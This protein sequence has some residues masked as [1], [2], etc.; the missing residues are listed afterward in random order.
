[1]TSPK[2]SINQTKQGVEQLDQESWD[3]VTILSTE[4]DF[5][6][7][8]EFKNI[9]NKWLKQ[10]NLHH[11]VTL[12]PEMVLL[13]ETDQHFAKAIQNAELKTPDG[14]GIIWA[15]WYKRSN[16]WSAIPSLLAFPFITVERITGIDAITTLALAAAKGNQSVYLLGSTSAARQQA[17]SKLLAQNSNLSIHYAPASSDDV[18]AD[19]A[20]IADIKLRR[21]AILL[22]AYGA[23]KQSIWIEQHRQHLA[24]AG[25]RIAIGIGGAFAMISETKPRAPRTSSTF[26]RRMVVA[27]RA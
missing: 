25:V 27:P 2:V 3:K 8:R 9:A 10:D 16:F 14:A 22:V 6:T 13:A 26:K 7:L 21:P 17:A 23:P 5:I 20:I 24:A 4:C 15:R 11:I 12:N 18:N 1:M 19:A